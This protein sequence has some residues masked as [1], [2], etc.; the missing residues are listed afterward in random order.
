MYLLKSISRVVSTK[1]KTYHLISNHKMNIFEIFYLSFCI[2]NK[3]SK[4]LLYFNFI[5]LKKLDIISFERKSSAL[6]LRESN[7]L[8]KYS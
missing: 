4:V 1:I 8:Y 7:I 6:T 3:N 5:S 2:Q